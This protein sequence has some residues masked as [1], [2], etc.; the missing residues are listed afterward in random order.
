MATQTQSLAN[1]Q[2]ALLSTGPRTDQGRQTSS[3]NAVAHGLFTLRD[4]VRPGE[5]EEYQRICSALRADLRPVGAL[6]ETFVMAITGAAWRLR[7]CS[8]VESEMS[9]TFSIDPLCDEAG[10]RL[11]RSVDRARGQAFNILRHSTAELR[12]LRK[13]RSA[14]AAQIHVVKSSND[15][16]SPQLASNC[17][18]T[19]DIPRSAPCPCGSGAKYKRCCGQTAAPVL[20]RAA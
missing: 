17:S 18:A 16:T 12:R 14:L 9:E 11:Q 19:A 15:E 7:R 3:Q 8:L 13:D 2:N 4:F 10:S 6:E 5:H 20:H 1:R